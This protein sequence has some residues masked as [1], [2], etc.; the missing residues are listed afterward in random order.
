MHADNGANYGSHHLVCGGVTVVV[1]VS[2]S[3]LFIRF[4]NHLFIFVEMFQRYLGFGH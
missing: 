4:K 3:L 1:M 2:E